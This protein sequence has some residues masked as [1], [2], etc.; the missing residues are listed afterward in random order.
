MVNGVIHEIVAFERDFWR[1]F[2]EHQ[3][4]IKSVLG[5]S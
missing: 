5:L 4:F 2:N 1:V 3:D